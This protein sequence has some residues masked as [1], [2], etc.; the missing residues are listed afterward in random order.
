LFVSPRIVSPNI[1]RSSTG[2]F[3]SASRAVNV[4]VFLPRFS[5]PAGG[6]IST[7]TLR[8]VI[9]MVSVTGA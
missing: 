7:C 5:L 8:G 3:V 4:T 6:D 9:G 1:T 2:S